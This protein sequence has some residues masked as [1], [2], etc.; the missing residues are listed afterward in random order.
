MTPYNTAI[1]M[2]TYLR[3][4]KHLRALSRLDANKTSS[5][6]D[7]MR[8]SGVAL[9]RGG[10]TRSWRGLAADSAIIIGCNGGEPDSGVNHTSEDPY[11]TRLEERRWLFD[12]GTKLIDYMYKYTV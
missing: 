6:F 11:E 7:E 12:N 2:N 5:E 10:A 9:P 8:C 1:G 3:T 4:K